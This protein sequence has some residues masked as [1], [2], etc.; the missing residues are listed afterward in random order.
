MKVQILAAVATMLLVTPGF[1][2]ADDAPQSNPRTRDAVRPAGAT[3]RAGD[4]AGDRAS[5]RSDQLEQFLVAH[6]RQMNQQEIDLSQRAAKTTTNAEVRAFAEEIAREHETLNKQLSAWQGVEPTIGQHGD[7]TGAHPAATDQPRVTDG[8][9]RVRTADQPR[10]T[11]SADRPRA[12]EGAVRP[13]TTEG[14]VRPRSGDTADRTGAANRGDRMHAHQGNNFARYA[15]IMTQASRNHQQ[16][17]LE[18]FEGY[19]GQDYDMAFLGHCMG[20]HMWMVSE[21]KA[22]NGVGSPEFQQV[23]QRS[24]EVASKHLQQAKNL[25]RKFED[26]RRNGSNVNQQGGTDAPRSTGAIAPSRTPGTD[27]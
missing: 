5:D 27:R 16:M 6:L 21:L 2:H 20:S 1:V 14:A 7:R 26:D 12:T 25:T 18:M 24:E 4:R 8:A 23:V 17:T 19:K 15:S 13:R 10:L 9:D 11:D 3:D 22:L